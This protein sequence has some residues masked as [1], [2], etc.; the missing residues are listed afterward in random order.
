MSDEALI[1]AYVKGQAVAF[2]CLYLRHKQSLYSFLVRQCTEQSVCEELAHDTWLAV[3]NQA[4]RFTPDARFKTWLYRIAHNRLVDYWRKHP[5]NR[6][7]L[8]EEVSEA[9]LA[10]KDNSAEMIELREL[11]ANL[12]VLSAEQ[13]EAL[14][15]K[16]EGFSH[17]EI[18]AITGAKRET[19]KSRLRYAT[20]HLRMS[21]EV[22]S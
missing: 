13:M 11:L 15:L 7:R 19:V 1:K 4:T 8:L 14:L 2:E 16:I 18:A 21:A 12:D 10:T 5:A 22:T 20:R 6:T 3:I 9:M 17:L